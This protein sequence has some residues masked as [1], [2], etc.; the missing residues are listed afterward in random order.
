MKRNKA[1]VFLTI[2]SLLL[3][4]TSVFPWSGWTSNDPQY[5]SSVVSVSRGVPNDGPS[6]GNPSDILGATNFLS[7]QDYYVYFNLGIGGSIT[8]G[9]D[10]PFKD[11]PGND[12]FVY[13]VGASENVTVTLLSSTGDITLLPVSWSSVGTRIYNGGIVHLN[14]F[15]FDIAQAGSF[16]YLIVN[17]NSEATSL[18]GADI[19]AVEVLY[20]VATPPSA[21]A[22]TSL[23]A[24]N[25]LQLNGTESSDPDG[26]QLT[27][28]WDITGNETQ[29]N[30]TGQIVS[31]ADLPV[32]DYEVTLTVSDGTYTDTDTMLLGIPAGAGEPPAPSNELQQQVQDAQD[33]VSNYS[34]DSFDAPND[35]ARENRRKALLNMLD[36]VSEHIETGDY[37]AAIDQL[38][39]ILA[40]SDGLAPPD[41]APDWIV[42]DTSTTEVN[43]QQEV[44]GL[45]SSLITDLEALL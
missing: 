44:A 27:F 10:K 45:V 14:R 5:A 29:S 12:I 13:E 28:S 37:Q 17:D 26:D 41:S 1:M 42:D 21:V 3:L 18:N 31:I 39:D 30:R 11:G 33:K 25:M 23:D 24:D 19:D 40:K 38:N 8:V 43:E 36:I 7:S 20:S 35:K 6:G 32:G 34:T 2:L 15:E 22:G 16:E 4:I 9:F